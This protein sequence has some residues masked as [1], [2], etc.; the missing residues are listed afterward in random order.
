MFMHCINVVKTCPKL[1][2]FKMY[3]P[4]NVLLRFFARSSISNDLSYIVFEAFCL[5]PICPVDV[6]LLFY[7]H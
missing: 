3:D 1:N 6:G 4:N 7:T 5:F 2:I